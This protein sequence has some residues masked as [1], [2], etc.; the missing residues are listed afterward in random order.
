MHA[1]Q[2]LKWIGGIL[3]AAFLTVG[4]AI[5]IFH[6][7]IVVDMNNPT[8]AQFWIS[9]F[10]LS[11]AF[12]LFV[13]F[14][15]WFVPKWKRNAGLFVLIFCL[16]FICLGTYHHFTDDGYLKEDHIIR[17]SSFLISLCIA[18]FAGHK[19]FGGKNW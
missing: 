7:V 10:F 15:C 4:V 17:Y 2:V 8:P 16:L 5:I 14:A 18:M 19:V 9:D 12:G 11:L 6:H 3:L 13:F 1:L